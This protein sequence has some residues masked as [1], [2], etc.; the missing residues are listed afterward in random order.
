MTMD[1]PGMMVAPFEPAPAVLGCPRCAAVVD[2]TSAHHRHQASLAETTRTWSPAKAR[3][4]IDT[5]MGY[6]NPR[7]VVRPA[8]PGPARWWASMRTTR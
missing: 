6:L 2:G 8:A 5:I 3:A 1:W 7:V 4:Y